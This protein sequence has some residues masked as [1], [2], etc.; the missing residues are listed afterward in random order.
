[1][2]VVSIHRFWGKRSAT[3]GAAAWMIT[4]PLPPASVFAASAAC[5][6]V[7]TLP[8]VVVRLFSKLVVRLPTL[9]SVP[10]CCETAEL[11]D[12]TAAEVAACWAL[13]T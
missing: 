4:F 3:A 10:A 5:C 11:S 1:M 2:P 12:S 8:L 6:A 7:V 9:D 13:A